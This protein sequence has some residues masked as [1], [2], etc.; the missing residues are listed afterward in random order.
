[1][2][3]NTTALMLNNSGKNLYEFDINDTICSTGIVDE[4]PKGSG[5][6]EIIYRRGKIEK[7]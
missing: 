3:F 1:V 5:S 7:I 4:Y 2:V 6:L